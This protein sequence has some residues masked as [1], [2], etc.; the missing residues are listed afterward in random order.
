MKKQTPHIT[1]EH[2]VAYLDGELNVS[3]EFEQEIQG[4]A[5][6][7]TAMREY[8]FI[9]KSFA[10]SSTDSRFMLSA[11]IDARAKAKLAGISRSRTAIRK[12][13]S[14]PSASPVHTQPA[15][16]S[17]TY[18]WA[19]R[20]GVGL[21]FAALL[22]FLFVNYSGKN[23]L[24]TQV[25]VPIMKTAPL[26][27]EK[28]PTA[29]PA[30]T[31]TRSEVAATISTE[32]SQRSPIAAKKNVVVTRNSESQNIAA[33]NVSADAPRAEMNAEEKTDRAAIMISHRYARMIKSTPVVE[34]TQH[35]R[36]VEQDRM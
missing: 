15:T 24:I 26:P 19:K 22:A 11:P 17:F 9:G 31:P 2:I 29:L 21:A 34:V 36:M 23:E 1:D 18:L 4:N 32:N 13:A 14:S 25:P 7:Q 12:A 10:K 27:T 35:D 8:A 3:P 28:A 16:R 6:L 20:T 33:N 5:E 30:E